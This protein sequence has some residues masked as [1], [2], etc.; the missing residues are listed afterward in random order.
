MLG[1]KLFNIKYYP[2]N[3]V[4]KETFCKVLKGLV[5]IGV[6]TPVK[7]SQYGTPVFLI[8]MKERTVRF[9]TDYL[10]IKYQL[11]R[12]LYLSPIKVETMQILEGFQYATVLDF[13]MRYYTIRLSPASQ[14]MTTIVTEFGKVRYNCFPMG[15]CASEYIFQSKVDKLLGDIKGIKAYINDKLFLSKDCS[16]NHIEQL[17]IIS[18]RLRSEGFKVNAPM[19]NFF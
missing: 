18:V 10:R 16:K 17:R 2:I 14:D 4:N 13:N 5:K 6:L 8:P 9:T 7:Q 1:S 11:V 3:G 19:C 12:K 15:M